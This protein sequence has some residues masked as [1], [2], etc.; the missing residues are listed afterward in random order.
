MDGSA[1][2]IGSDIGGSLR[3]PAAYCGIYS[4][5]PSHGR[6]NS[7]G[8]RTPNPGFEGVKVV[9]GPMGRSVKD[10]DLL[11][12]IAFGAQG[13]TPTAPVLYRQVT[14]PSKLKFGYYTS[15]CYI[16]ASPACKRAV[17]ETVE[18]LRREGHEC[19]EFEIPSPTKAVELFLAISSSDGYKSL[20]APLGPDPKEDCLFLTTLGPKLGWI[21]QSIAVWALKTF[22]KDPIFAQT[23]RQSRVKPVDEYI[24]LTQERNAYDDLW[25]QE[26]WGKHKFDGII[27][28]VQAMPVI[29]HGDCSMLS[30][31]AA[32]TILYNVVDSPAGCV[33]V[34]RVDP[35]KDQV[36]EEWTTGP[37]LGSKVLEGALYHA[38]KPIYDPEE[39]EGMPVGVQIVGK[40][41]DDEK[42]LAMMDVVDKALGPRG[43]G[44]GSWHQG[45]KDA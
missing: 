14:L 42:V 24:A 16:K 28:P 34:T 6:I 2:G 36:T 22:F 33:P 37:G 13:H 41:W 31:L 17:L 26:V 11:C 15:D 10:V 19:V 9:M 35:T 27:A 18:A 30:P 40:K 5:K 38:K 44:P 12:R 3:I 39:L 4:L 32:S 7:E 8:A 1:F 23:V 45:K 25:Y 43:F 20:L 21:V 29:H